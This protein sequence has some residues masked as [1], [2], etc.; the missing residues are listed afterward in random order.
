MLTRIDHEAQDVSPIGVS[1]NNFNH[2]NSPLDEPLDLR[3]LV[4]KLPQIETQDELD[5]IAHKWRSGHGNLGH[6]NPFPEYENP[7]L[8]DIPAILKRTTQLLHKEPNNH[9]EYLNL[10]E[11]T[12]KNLLVLVDQDQAKMDKIQEEIF[13][14]DDIMGDLSRLETEARTNGSN[15][16]ELDDDI[17]DKIE[18]FQR[19]HWPQLKK[20]STVRDFDKQN[21]FPFKANFSTM[22]IDSISAMKSKVAGLISYQN[23]DRSTIGRNMER[24]AQ[25]VTLITEVVAKLNAENPFIKAC[26]RGQRT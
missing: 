10:Y 20:R 19:I 2:E 25:L 9:L 6:L 18:D 5:E 16:I 12:T 24:N 13:C 22:S 26:L 21:P 4:E 14:L 7:E 1:K 3:D 15:A 17:L 11:K 8:S 23:S